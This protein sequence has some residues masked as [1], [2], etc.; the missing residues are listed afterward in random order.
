MQILNWMTSDMSN[1][2]TS[3]I[4]M[5]TAVENYSLHEF[6]SM[7]DLRIGLPEANQITYA[8]ST[9][10]FIAEDSYFCIG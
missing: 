2:Q 7:N 1:A 9:S 4:D 8:T 5:P 3:P 10:D 6:A